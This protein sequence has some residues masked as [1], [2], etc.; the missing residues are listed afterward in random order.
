MRKNLS[1]LTFLMLK[2]ELKRVTDLE[3][4]NAFFDT[5]TD[6]LTLELKFEK[7]GEQK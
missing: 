4:I 6:I 5:K 7:Q 1:K 3:L 2:K